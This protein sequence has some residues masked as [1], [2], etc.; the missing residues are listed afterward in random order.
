MPGPSPDL[1]FQPQ[2][3]AA[4]SALPANEELR[5]QLLR[6]EGR[7]QMLRETLAKLETSLLTVVVPQ[8]FEG[9]LGLTMQGTQVAAVT[10]QRAASF[11]WMAGDVI[12]KVNGVM[13]QSIG[14]FTTELSRAIAAYNAQRRPLVFE[15]QRQPA[16]ATPCYVSQP[17]LVPPTVIP[18]QIPA[19]PAVLPAAPVSPR[20]PP[21]SQIAP[22]VMP[23]SP[24]G[25][26]VDMALLPPWHE[27]AGY[28]GGLPPTKLGPKPRRNMLCL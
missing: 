19:P 5:Q 12:Q 16:A 26:L 28:L 9:K 25:H 1:V 11:G 4:P 2:P 18:I 17:L 8:L 27:S 13:V 14:D 20:Y 22:S 10:D 15:I 23:V 24:P 7:A 21:D 3:F 6:T